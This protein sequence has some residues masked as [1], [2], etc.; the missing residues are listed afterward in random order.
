MN[1]NRREIVAILEA[2]AKKMVEARTIETQADFS[3]QGA[4][5]SIQFYRGDI[6]LAYSCAWGLLDLAF[7]EIVDLRAENAQLRETI[8][9]LG[10]K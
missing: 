6:M 10:E 5:E 8:E 7:A 2:R 9:M 4:A 1:I 3:A